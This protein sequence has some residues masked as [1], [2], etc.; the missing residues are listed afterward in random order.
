[1][2]QD[3]TPPAGREQ[4]GAVPLTMLPPGVRGTVVA[5][6]GGGGF[7]QRLASM[8]IHQGAEVCVIRAGQGGPVIVRAGEGRFILGRGMAYRIMVRPL[9]E[10]S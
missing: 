7:V 1:M 3:D 10:G 5:L 2:T 4:H 8:G 9:Q 6:Y